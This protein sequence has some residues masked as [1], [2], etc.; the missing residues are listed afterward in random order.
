MFCRSMFFC[1][2]NQ[3]LSPRCDLS[4]SFRLEDNFVVPGEL[5]VSMGTDGTDDQV[6]EAFYSASYLQLTDCFSICCT[7]SFDVACHVAT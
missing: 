1:P 4:S 5:D 2:F 6:L 7:L 3:L